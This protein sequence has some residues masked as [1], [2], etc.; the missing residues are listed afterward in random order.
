M[1][2]IQGGAKVSLPKRKLNISITVRANELLFFI[3]D[4]SMF[5]LYI[6]KDMPKDTLC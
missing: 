2:R 3:N 1:L 4:R 5:K 6:D